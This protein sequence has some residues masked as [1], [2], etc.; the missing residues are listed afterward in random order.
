RAHLRL[1]RRQRGRRGGVRLHVHP[2]AHGAARAAG[3]LDRQ[4]R[5][6][7]GRRALLPGLL[8][9]PGPARDDDGPAGAAHPAVR[10]LR[11]RP[12][13][14]CGQAA[15][16]RRAGAGG[17]MAIADEAPLVLRDV[18]GPSALG[19]S[20]RRALDLLYVIAVNDFKRTYFGTV[21]GYLWSVA[22]PLMQFAVLLA[23]FT[24]VFHFASKVPHYPVFLL[25]NIV[26]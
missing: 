23:V 12:A 14:R 5:E 19:G 1:P 24:H 11:H 18:P 6:P 25:F 2:G 15:R 8:G 3:A 17:L 20:R 10:R 26:L 16:R 22:R 9:P 13:P 4:D 21:L 7:A